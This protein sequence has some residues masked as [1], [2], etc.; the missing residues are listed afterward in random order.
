[1]PKSDKT[2]EN[3]IWTPPK[4][5]QEISSETGQEMSR[6]AI[7]RFFPKRAT[8]FAHNIQAL[9][10]RLVENNERT[11]R[12]NAM[13]AASPSNSKVFFPNGFFLR[14]RSPEDR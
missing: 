3:P 10:P 9:I 12:D 14:K 7:K 8:G 5:D 4:T 13:R 1:M 6:A 11:E 2:N